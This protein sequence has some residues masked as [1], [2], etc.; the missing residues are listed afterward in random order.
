MEGK[1]TTNQKSIISSLLISINFDI[2]TFF[3]SG[4]VRI[5]QGVQSE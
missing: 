3:L 1:K 2:L 4:I 5:A